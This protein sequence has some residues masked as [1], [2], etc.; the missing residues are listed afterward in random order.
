[1]HYFND[2]FYVW[3]YCDK[4]GTEKANFSLSFYPNPASDIAN[5]VIVEDENVIQKGNDC[6]IYMVDK[7][8]RV[9][10]NTK[11]KSRKL[12]I[13]VSNLPLGSYNIIGIIG[14]K[15]SSIRLEVLH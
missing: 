4:K 2:N 9:V 5:L 13:N 1:M 10:Y 3:V 11:T 6:I 7:S 15:K 8:G 12:D 14:G